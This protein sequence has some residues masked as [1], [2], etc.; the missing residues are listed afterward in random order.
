[1]TQNKS[2]G[3]RT[4]IQPAVAF[5]AMSCAKCLKHFTVPRLLQHVLLSAIKKREDKNIQKYNFAGSFV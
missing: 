2:H 5:T 3:Q 4:N 1:L